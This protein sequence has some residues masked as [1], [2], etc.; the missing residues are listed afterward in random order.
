MALKRLRIFANAGKIEATSSG[1]CG[2]LN[3]GSATRGVHLLSSRS[4][5]ILMPQYEGSH[6]CVAI[7][8]NCRSAVPSLI[9]KPRIG[10]R[11]GGHVPMTMVPRPTDRLLV[12]SVLPWA[13]RRSHSSLSGSHICL[14]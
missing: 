3:A 2:E 4:T 8:E 11:F 5:L 14:Q 13:S 10:A 9:T 7:N 1:T 12:R 6:G